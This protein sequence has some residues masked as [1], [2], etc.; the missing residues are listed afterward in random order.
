MVTSRSGRRAR[1][2][3]RVRTESSKVSQRGDPE[4]AVVVVVLPVRRHRTEVQSV[5]Q[6][7][8]RVSVW[9]KGKLYDFGVA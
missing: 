8:E 7:R 9:G 5:G 6:D 2:E 3:E 1:V 4:K